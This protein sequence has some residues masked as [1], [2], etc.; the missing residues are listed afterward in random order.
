MEIKKN[1]FGKTENGQ[2]VD[3]Y[4][5]TNKNGMKA[6]CLNYGGIITQLWAPDKNGKIQDIILGYESMDGILADTTCYLGTLVGRYANR[7]GRGEFSL[8]GKT[9]KLARNNNGNHLHG[10]DKGFNRVIFD[11]KVVKKG[12]G[13]SLKLSYLSRDGEEGYPGNLDVTIYYTLAETNEFSIDYEATTDKRTIVNLT[14][15]MYFNLTGDCEKDILKH[16]LMLNADRYTPTDSGLIPTGELLPVKGTP[17]DFTGMI[18]IGARINDNQRMLK[19][20]GGYDLNYVLNKKDAGLETAAKLY[21]PTSGRIM[22]LLTMEPGIQFYCGNFLDGTKLGKGGK[23]IK[24]R[25]G[26]CLE[27]Q[28][29]PDSPNKPDFPSTVLEPGKKY[30]SRTVY[31]FLNER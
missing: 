12:A 16:E 14:N 21:E 19:L 2:N 5:L 6:I 9:Y 1:S 30:Q 17:L 13:S 18:S 20:A 23:A 31:R 22:E 26:L 4:T 7:I 27:P 24:Y 10:G 11:V 25:C 29:F 28:H 3:A 15:H 8:D